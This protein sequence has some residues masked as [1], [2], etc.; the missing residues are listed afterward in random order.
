VAGELERDYECPHC[1]VRAIVAVDVEATMT[2][3][4]RLEAGRLARAGDM[5][6]QD[7]A[8]RTL[9]LVRCPQCGARPP[10]AL[11]WSSLRVVGYTLGSV[12][13]ML[14]LLRWA[15][16][17]VPIWTFG[18]GTVAAGVAGVAVEVRRWRAAAKIR[19][20]RMREPAPERSLPV[21]TVVK[22]GAE[23]APTSQPL[24]PLST[25]APDRG[26]GAPIGDKP[27]MLD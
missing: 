14:V 27:R 4:E 10:M 26:D 11:L 20:V 9:G 23:P 25:E 3:W 8:T 19:I 6:T 21:A 12:L 5:A 13:V 18:V 15:I 7:D 16:G 24:A 2:P 17:L 22:G 1:K